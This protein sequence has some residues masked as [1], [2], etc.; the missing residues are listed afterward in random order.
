MIYE[1]PVCYEFPNVKVRTL[2]IIGQSDRTVVGKARMKKEFVPL[3]GNY[4]ELGRKTARLIPRAKLV[5]IQNAGHIPRFEFPDRYHEELLR[6]L[7]E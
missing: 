3:A 6:F 7:K 1:Q 4:P 5:E 2:L